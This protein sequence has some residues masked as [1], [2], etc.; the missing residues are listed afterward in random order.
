MD[1]E[2]IYNNFDDEDDYIYN[3]FIKGEIVIN[4]NDFSFFYYKCKLCKFNNNTGQCQKI[5]NEEYEGALATVNREYIFINNVG[6][7]MKIIEKNLTDSKDMY[8]NFCF[9][10]LYNGVLRQRQENSKNSI[11]ID[12]YNF[13]STVK[14]ICKEEMV[15]V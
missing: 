10:Y 15:F 1:L 6:E 7:N 4:S 8:Y 11:Q 9:Y 12:V 3:K 5:E 2:E 13:L 14:D